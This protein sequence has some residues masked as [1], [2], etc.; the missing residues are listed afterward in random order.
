M[1]RIN[2]MHNIV[3]TLDNETQKQYTR[4]K[5]IIILNSH[6]EL[7]FIKIKNEGQRNEAIKNEYVKYSCSKK[8]VNQETA[9]KE[10]KR[11]KKELEEFFGKQEYLKVRDFKKRLSYAQNVLNSL[12]YRG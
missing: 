9:E 5:G 12:G 3:T 4:G 7:P 2:Y 10:Y 8:K 6:L 11:K 1:C